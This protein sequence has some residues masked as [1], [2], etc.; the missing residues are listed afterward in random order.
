MEGQVGPSQPALQEK[1]PGAEIEY[2]P[3]PFTHP[4]E[5]GLPGPWAGVFAVRDGPEKPMWAA[6]D[7]SPGGSK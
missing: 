3:L 2:D 1:K 4:G 7:L 6:S 5:A